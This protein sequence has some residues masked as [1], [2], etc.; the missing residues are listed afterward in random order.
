MSV[1]Q[2]GDPMSDQPSEGALRAAKVFLKD[3]AGGKWKPDV[4][5]QLA[6]IIDEQTGLRE[7]VE[8]LRKM[9][10]LVHTLENDRDFDLTTEQKAIAMEAHLATRALSKHGRKGT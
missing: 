3:F 9:V 6:R 2:K 1:E 5:D 7:C 10:G 4:A 8:A